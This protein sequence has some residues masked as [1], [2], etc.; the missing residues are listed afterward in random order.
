MHIAVWLPDN[1]LIPRKT[2]KPPLWM[3]ARYMESRGRS[4]IIGIPFTN[5]PPSDT[6]IPLYPSLNLS[7]IHT[8]VHLSVCPPLLENINISRWSLSICVTYFYSNFLL[9][10]KCF[11]KFVW[12]F[13]IKDLLIHYFEAFSPINLITNLRF[14]GQVCL[15]SF[16]SSLRFF[17]PFYLNN[18]CTILFLLFL[19]VIFIII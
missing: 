15:V 16:Q 13:A 9:H 6:S 19:F 12:P 2:P 11:T 18:F 10:F 17:P 1:S 3:K 7:A 8:Y 14:R 4:Y 5:P